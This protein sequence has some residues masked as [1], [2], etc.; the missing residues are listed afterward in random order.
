MEQINITYDLFLNAK[1]QINSIPPNYVEALNTLRKIPVECETMCIE[2][3]KVLCLFM[4][5]HFEDIIEYYYTNKAKVLAY[6]SLNEDFKKLI[7]CAFLACGMFHRAHA[8]CACVTPQYEVSSPAIDVSFIAS[9]RA[10]S[11]SI[12]NEIHFGIVND[13]KQQEIN[14]NSRN[15]RDNDNEIALTLLE[16][17]MKFNDDDDVVDYTEKYKQ[18]FQINDSDNCLFPRTKTFVGKVAVFTDMALLPTATERTEFRA[19]RKRNKKG[20]AKQIVHSELFISG[21]REERFSKRSEEFVIESYVISNTLISEKIRCAVEKRED[22]INEDNEEGSDDEDRKDK[23]KETKTVYSTKSAMSKANDSKMNVKNSNHSSNR[24]MP[25]ANSKRKENG[26]PPRIKHKDDSGSSAHV[27][28]NCDVRS[29]GGTAYV[30]RDDKL[31]TA[32]LPKPDNA[33]IPRTKTDIY[34]TSNNSNINGN[35]CT[36]VNSSTKKA[37]NTEDNSNSS[38]DTHVAASPHNTSTNTNKNEHSPLKLVK[39]SFNIETA[40]K[41]NPK[42]CATHIHPTMAEYSVDPPSQASLY[43]GTDRQTLPVKK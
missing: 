28:V 34:K 43:S 1:D 25:V 2:H 18:Y 10:K 30:K 26:P 3:M 11:T 33:T 39:G 42:K 6:I 17:K 16:D 12:V 32:M 24:S 19:E 23:E 15:V 9:T 29:E 40:T 8:L 38:H 7:A 20:F 31:R 27:D 22:D 36:H 37:I 14:E 21:E 41:F 4:L 35:N 13:N 5:E